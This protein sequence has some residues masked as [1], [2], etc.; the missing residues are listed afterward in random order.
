MYPGFL[1]VF[2]VE[3]ST[4]AHCEVCWR[5]FMKNC[6]CFLVNLS[7]SSSSVSTTSQPQASSFW[8]ER[9][10]FCLERF[11]LLLSVS[12]LLCQLWQLLA[13][14][15]LGR[16]GIQSVFDDADAERVDDALLLKSKFG[17]EEFW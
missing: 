14:S 2:S 10:I 6:C 3:Q 17:C 4:K 16:S 1:G 15:R 13:V 5:D 8:L 7:S 9:R 12:V 11:L